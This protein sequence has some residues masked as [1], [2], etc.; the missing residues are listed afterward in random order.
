MDEI[1]KYSECDGEIIITGLQEGVAETAIV[2]PEA[3]DNMPVTAIAD[4]AF[5]GSH[6]ANVKIGENIKAVG[7]EAFEGCKDLKSVVW[8]CSCS[9]IPSCCFYSCTALKQF[10]FS[11]INVTKIESSAFQNTAITDIKIGENIKEIGGAAFS[12]C[13]NLK[14]VVW[15]TSCDIS[16]SC[17]FD[18]PKLSKFD[19]SNVK[20]IGGRAFSE[21]GIKKVELSENIEE[22]GWGAFFKCNKLKQ[23]IW[24]SACEEIPLNCFT[25][26]SS[27]IQFDFSKVKKIGRCAFEGSGLQELYL[28]PNVKEIKAVAFA[29]CTALK[30]VTWDCDCNKVPTLCFA[31]CFSLKHFDFN[32]IAEIGTE[33]FKKCKLHE[34]F[35][36]ENIKNVLSLAFANCSELKE[37]NISDKVESIATNAFRDCPNAEFN[38]V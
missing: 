6:I 29:D 34:L 13:K 36:P 5:K 12:H 17:F 9:K 3:I 7:A 15:N 26:C 37:I 18:C 21:S 31:N 14:N 25:Y 38:F 4:E 27:L 32:N 24:N 33:A 20:K 11:N 1:F 30:Q 2:I 22:V 8:N 28:P 35:L 23:V 16:Y 19:L 10:D